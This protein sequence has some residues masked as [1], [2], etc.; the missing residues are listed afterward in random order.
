MHIKGFSW[1]GVGVEDFRSAL[2]FFEDVLGLKRMIVDERGVAILEVADGQLLEIFGPGTNG[3]E[4]NS[5]PVAAF[6]VEDVD[7]ACEEL[8]ARGI[9]LVGDVGRWNGFEWAYFRGP[10][11]YLFSVKRTPPRGWEQNS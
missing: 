4:L 1:L 11:D 10:N 9:E 7:A 6:E 3:S 8:R 5:P 2:S